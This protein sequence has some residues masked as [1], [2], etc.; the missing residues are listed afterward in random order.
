M[1]RDQSLYFL[2]NV[3]VSDLLLSILQVLNKLLFGLFGVE[4]DYNL[5]FLVEEF[6]CP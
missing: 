3:G 1:E 6:A 5:S 2:L 4:I